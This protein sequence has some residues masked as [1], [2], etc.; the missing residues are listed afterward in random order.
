[1]VSSDTELPSSVETE[2]SDSFVDDSSVVLPVIS[3]LLTE[4][5][6]LPPVISVLLPV[7]S[8]LPSDV[9]IVDISEEAVI[10]VSDDSVEPVSDR[11]DSVDPDTT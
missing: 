11:L 8:V 2:A 6:V 1:M 9:L 5:S 7:M 10:G 3:V 4:I